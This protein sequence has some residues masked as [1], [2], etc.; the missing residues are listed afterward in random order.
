MSESLPLDQEEHFKFLVHL[1]LFAL[2]TTS[3]L[4][5]LGAWMSCG[6]KLNRNNVIIYSTFMACE[7]Y[8]CYQHR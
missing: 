7:V 5:N 8:Q 1:A 4:Y 3:M 2:S 6:K